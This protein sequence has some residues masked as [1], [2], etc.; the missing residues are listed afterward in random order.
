[1]SDCSLLFEIFLTYK[2]IL[3]KHFFCYLFLP[4]TTPPTYQICGF[5]MSLPGFGY[6]KLNLILVQFSFHDH[7][8]TIDDECICFIMQS[9]ICTARKFIFFGHNY[10]KAIVTIIKILTLALILIITLNP[11]HTNLN[12]NPYP[13]LMQFVVGAG[14]NEPFTLAGQH[15]TRPLL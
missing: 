7:S 11:N 14:V 9:D 4:R 2:Y 10:I 12:P 6:L 1:M 8:D 3:N 13:A 15:S 5:R